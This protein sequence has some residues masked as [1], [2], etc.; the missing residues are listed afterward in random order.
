LNKLLNVIG[1]AN[2]AK[3]V[4]DDALNGESFIIFILNLFSL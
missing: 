1:D 4:K 3:L 2:F